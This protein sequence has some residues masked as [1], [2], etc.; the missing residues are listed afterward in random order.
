VTKEGKGQRKGNKKKMSH[1]KAREEERNEKEVF[2]TGQRR[3]VQA[4]RSTHTEGK[5]L[6]GP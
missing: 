5:N 4:S 2:C 3:E 6:G 1:P